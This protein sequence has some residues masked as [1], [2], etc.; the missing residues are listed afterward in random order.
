MLLW[1]LTEE[2]DTES[3][4]PH[5]TGSVQSVPVSH[6]HFHVFVCLCAF[7][8]PCFPC[9]THTRT[10]IYIDV[11]TH[12]Y[13]PPHVHISRHAY[14]HVYILTRTYMRAHTHPDAHTH[15]LMCA[16]ECVC[17]VSHSMSGSRPLPS[18]W[19]ERISTSTG[20]PYYFNA[21][22]GE[23]CWEFPERTSTSNRECCCHP[24]PQ[25]HR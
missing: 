13:I 15:A 18:G 6:L 11:H 1:K 8:V 25:A 17:L 22:T 21:S 3:A 9:Y 16:R 5:H 10:Y 4:Q 20:K 2:S 24:T 19:E 23:S 14:I 12:T 7:L